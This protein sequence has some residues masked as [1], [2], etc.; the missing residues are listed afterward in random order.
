MKENELDQKLSNCILVSLDDENMLMTSQTFDEIISILPMFGSYKEK[1][2]GLYNIINKE[3]SQNFIASTKNSKKNFL[4]GF[5]KKNKPIS[6]TKYK[7]LIYN[8]TSQEEVACEKILEIFRDCL[9]FNIMKKI[10]LEP[11]FSNSDKEVN[12]KKFFKNSLISISK[13]T[14]L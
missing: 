12:F 2:R 14:G 6:P 11:K 5:N 1:I 4:F 13:V 7:R 10:P 8:P 9:N 3:P